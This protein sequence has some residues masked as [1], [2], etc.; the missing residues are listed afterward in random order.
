MV[1]G[2]LVMQ[3]H[4]LIPYRTVHPSA[5]ASFSI[6]SFNHVAP[7]LYSRNLH[8][9]NSLPNQ[10]LNR[11]PSTGASY[12]S[13][14]PW[15]PDGHYL[16]ATSCRERKPRPSYRSRRYFLYPKSA[17]VNTSLSPSPKKRGNSPSKNLTRPSKVCARPET[18]VPTVARRVWKTPRMALR[19]DWKIAMMEPRAAVM[20]WK[21]EEMSEPSWSTA[22]GM[23]A[24]CCVEAG[25]TIVNAEL[26]GGGRMER[27][28][29]SP[30]DCTCMEFSFLC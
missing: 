16:A 25:T 23:F 12:S 21:M 26:A 4:S 24:V 19:M 10:L 14:E 11:N 8:F 17:S 29:H 6:Q 3:A 1:S 9:P 30:K 27:C 18:A 28:T 20:L 7:C 15:S 2:Y 5:T 22:E 13:Q